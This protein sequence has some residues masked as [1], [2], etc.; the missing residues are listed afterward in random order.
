MARAVAHTGPYSR[1]APLVAFGCPSERATIAHF[2]C[3]A[4]LIGR[5]P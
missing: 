4:L 3:T 1:L 5:T 2:V